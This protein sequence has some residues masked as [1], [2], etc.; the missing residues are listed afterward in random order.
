MVIDYGRDRW[1][2]TTPYA[3][4]PIWPWTTEGQ[5]VPN[6]PAIPQGER[7]R[8]KVEIAEFREILTRAREWDAAHNLADCESDD[9]IAKIRQ[10]A[11][12]LGI[13]DEVNGVLTDVLAVPEAKKRK[14][15][16]K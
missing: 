3:P 15:K 13:L 16:G 4:P 9:K 2:R 14:R 8:L 10:V 1:D 12:E 6:D 5:L 11:E 7:E